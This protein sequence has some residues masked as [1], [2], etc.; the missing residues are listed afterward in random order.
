MVD[1]QKHY[2]YFGYKCKG[3][4]IIKIDSQDAD[5]SFLF[6]D[7]VESKLLVIECPDCP[8]PGTPCILKQNDIGK[9]VL[10][11]LMGRKPKFRWE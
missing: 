8:I 5:C 6:S 1:K 9:T 3:M 11:L 2:R 7:P 4:R 10:P